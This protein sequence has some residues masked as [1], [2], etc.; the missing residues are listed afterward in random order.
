[1]ALFGIMQGKSS[2]LYALLGEMNLMNGSCFLPS[3]IVRPVD[4]DPGEILT[5]SVAFCAQ[6][7]WLL[8]DT[9]RN[10]ILFG[11]TYNERRYRQVLYACALLPDLA[12]LELGDKT[13]VGE[14]G[15]ALSGGQ[16]ARIS[17]ARAVYSS[18]KVLLLDD[19][20]SAVE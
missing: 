13:Q 10:N 5:D 11:L 7:P 14:K 6:T 8:N 4:I 12:V 16:K 20:L 19:V 17:L 9:I 3:P 18:A 2:L 1:M 15:T